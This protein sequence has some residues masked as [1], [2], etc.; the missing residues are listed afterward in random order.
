MTQ[1]RL[2]VVHGMGSDAVGLV[3]RIT[4]PIAQAKG[5]IQDLRQDVLHGLFTIYMVVDLTRSRLEPEGFLRMIDE[6]SEDTGLRITAQ[7]YSPVPRRPEKQNLLMILVG[8]DKPGIIATSSALLGKYNAN[9][10]FAQTIAREG[11]FLME[12]Q[13]SDPCPRK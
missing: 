5:N 3:G 9:I 13:Q 6:I 4:A 1:Q 7:R 12:H 11:I 8:I 2:F 10:E